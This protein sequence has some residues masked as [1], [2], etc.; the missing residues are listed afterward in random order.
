MFFSGRL[1]GGS[2]LVTCLVSS[3]SLH[4][5]L[6]LSAPAT[7]RPVLFLLLTRKEKGKDSPRELVHAISKKCLTVVSYRWNL[8]ISA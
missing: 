4:Q 8:S 1:P 3:K 6:Y 5:G 7:T 2:R